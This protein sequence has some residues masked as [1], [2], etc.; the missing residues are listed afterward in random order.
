MGIWQVGIDESSGRA[1]GEPQLIAAGVDAEMDLP[2]LSRD[3]TSILFRSKLESVN[4]A[5]ITL[6]AAG[7]R[8][9]SV[10]LL[11]KRSGARSCLGTLSCARA[12]RCRTNLT[13]W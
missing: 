12:L 4:P 10:R 13:C 1:R 2:H 6:D 7:T 3:G 8:I 5:V 11:Q 9:E